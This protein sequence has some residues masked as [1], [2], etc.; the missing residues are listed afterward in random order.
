LITSANELE[1]VDLA[2]VFD[3]QA[4]SVEHLPA[5]ESDWLAS[6]LRG[7]LKLPRPIAAL[8][9]PDDARLRERPRMSS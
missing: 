3:I 2:A 1:R 7:S 4:E 8:N 9:R 6:S 5:S